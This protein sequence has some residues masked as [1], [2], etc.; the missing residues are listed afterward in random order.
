MRLLVYETTGEKTD[1]RK[2]VV[3]VFHHLRGF[4]VN[5]ASHNGGPIILFPYLYRLYCT[6]L[7][8]CLKCPH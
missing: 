3:I 1:I 4:L 2:F 6:R 5:S 8:C 7:N